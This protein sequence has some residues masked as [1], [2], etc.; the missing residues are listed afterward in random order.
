MAGIGAWPNAVWAP[1][2]TSA[3][4]SVL[5]P[6]RT[7]LRIGDFSLC[8]NRSARRPIR[9]GLSKTRGKHATG[10]GDRTRIRRRKAVGNYG[11]LRAIDRQEGVSTAVNS[12][13]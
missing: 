7:E 2:S 13:G 4:H 9:H 5:P 12:G 10:L 8:G 3:A 6:T 11:F 1:A